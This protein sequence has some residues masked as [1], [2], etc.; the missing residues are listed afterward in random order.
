MKKN[1]LCTSKL[2]FSHQIL[3][4]F[5]SQKNIVYDLNVWFWFPGWL[6][7]IQTVDFKLENKIK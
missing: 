7:R 3:L 1:P 6:L 5:A 4:K 2:Y